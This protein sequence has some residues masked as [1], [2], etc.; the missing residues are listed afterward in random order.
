MLMAATPVHRRW[1]VMRM[2][3]STYQAASG[4]GREAMLELETQSRD[5]LHGKD[6][7]PRFFAEPCAFNVFSHNTPI[8]DQGFNG[9]EKKMLTETQRI[10][11]NPQIHVLATCIRVPVMRAHCESIHLTL[12][13]GVQS[14]DEIRACIA[15]FEG[16]ELLDDR[17]GNV[18]PTPLKA[19]GRDDVLVGR[20]RLDESTRDSKGFCHGVSLFA[21]GDQL[22]KGAALNAIQIAQS[23]LARAPTTTPA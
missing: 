3:V 6:A 14:I 10:W 5:I 19:T 20:L 1:G 15:E 18:F 9:E 16:V 17:A 11:D 2:I 4:A 7:V 12:E 22:R 21:A 23:L 8:D 13:N